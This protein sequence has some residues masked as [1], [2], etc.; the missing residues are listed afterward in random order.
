MLLFIR[1]GGFWKSDVRIQ[2]TDL[3]S[4]TLAYIYDSHKCSA[5]APDYLKILHNKI[6]RVELYSETYK[7]YTLEN[8]A[9]AD[10]YDEDI[11]QL[12]FAQAVKFVEHNADSPDPEIQ[13]QIA[14]LQHLLF[15][16][17]NNDTRGYTYTYELKQQLS[18][19]ELR[20]LSDQAWAIHVVQHDACAG[21]IILPDRRHLLTAGKWH[22][23]LLFPPYQIISSI[24]CA[25][26]PRPRLGTKTMAWERT[27]FTQGSFREYRLFCETGRASMR[28][29]FRNSSHRFGTHLILHFIPPYSPA[30][31]FRRW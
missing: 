29:V 7:T 28:T 8:S 4:G 23:H 3:I 17:M 24:A 21:W 20:N 2:I 18:N 5:D 12:C 13:A 9:I 6:I 19:T 14:V 22:I 11:A 30:P 26:T 15:R 16:F 31:F 1:Q 27:P 25:Y 10:D